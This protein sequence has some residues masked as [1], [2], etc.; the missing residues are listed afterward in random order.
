MG[1][2]QQVTSQAT[3]PQPMGPSG[4][5]F[6]KELGPD[7]VGLYPCPGRVWAAAEFAVAFGFLLEPHELALVRRHAG[8]LVDIAIPDGYARCLSRSAEFASADVPA[9]VARRS[10]SRS[11]C[12]PEL[13]LKFKGCRPVSGG[14]T[15]PLEVLAPGATTIQHT[16]IPFGTVSAEGVMREL[17]GWAFHREH[18]LPIHSTPVGVYEYTA[19]GLSLGCCLVSETRGEDR[20]EA[21]IEY[22]SC[23]VAEIIRAKKDGQDHVGN[24]VLGSEL[25]LQGV[26]LW[27]YVEEKS[28][29]LCAMHFHGGS[30]GIL[31]SNIGNDV[32]LRCPNGK[33]ELCLCDFDT[34]RVE[35]V[36]DIP[37]DAFLN[38]FTLRATIEVVKGSLSICDYVEIPNDA[39]S[40]EVVS[41][42]G[43]VYFEKSSIWRAYL[44]RFDQAV[45]SSGWDAKMVQAAF[46]NARRTEALASV[47]ASCVVNSHYLQRMSGDRT[48]FYPHN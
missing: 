34:F 45:R 48:V 16:T 5:D 30:R 4:R 23:T 44:R 36:P 6:P 41:A 46:A 7:S 42:L 15:Y 33:T 13:Q 3:T 19:A 20:I 2:S 21:H 31:N 27:W 24:S 38:D 43:R 26:N 9:F 28:Q 32:L 17:L 47:L 35:R 40:S 25:K 10:G 39:S 29:L 1:V 18:G 12:L 11:A 37:D 22:P 8:V 14:S